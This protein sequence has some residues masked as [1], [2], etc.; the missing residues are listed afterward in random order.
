M[1]VH[2]YITQRIE[3]LFEAVPHS[4]TILI[5]NPKY[6][7]FLYG[8]LFK[9]TLDTQIGHCSEL[10]PVVSSCGTAGGMA[11]FAEVQKSL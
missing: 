1:S 10:H 8:L 4:M 3:A 9:A 7:L 5:L 11:A 2:I 6:G